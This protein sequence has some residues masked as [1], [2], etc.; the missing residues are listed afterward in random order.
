[1]QT[2]TPAAALASV[3]CVATVAAQSP[4][5]PG[6]EPAIH[7]P[8]ITQQMIT[9]GA[10]SARAIRTH[11]L[12]MF[13]TPFNTLDGYGDGP[14]DP[15]N[16]TSP[17]GRPTLQGNGML[18][19]VNGLD[20][21]T[22]T[23]CHSLLSTAEVPFRFGIGGF[24]GANNNVLFMPRH[25]DVSDSNGNGFAAFDGRFI[26]PPFLLGAG[27]V[28]LVAKEMTLELQAAR[29]AAQANQGVWVP[30]QTKG[31]SFGEILWNGASFD[32]SRIEGIDDDLVVRPFGRKGEFP[33]IRSFDVEALRF[34]LGM[35][36]V[37][38]VGRNIDADGDGV[39]NEVLVG[40]VSALS[41]FAA[42]L[43]RPIEVRGDRD[44]AHGRALFSRLGCAQ[45]HVPEIDTHS[46]LLPH[47][48]PEVPTDPLANIY[49]LTD[50]RQS[51]KFD[52]AGG[53]GI[54]RTAVLGPQAS[55]HGQSPGRV[56]RHDPSTG[57]S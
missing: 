22:C 9:S 18:L 23:E 34:H 11:G 26:N 1:M 43:E 2:L 57:C 49:Y 12:R 55:R 24:G 39:V 36:P 17:G 6:E 19:R 29:A 28:E 8:R 3:L 53:G 30:L 54:A 21:Q 46:R 37:E 48:Y 5:M 50:L 32:T 16:T 7:P 25:I 27:G 44:S 20:A 41:I 42:S 14:M 51:A 13:A 45:C 47:A 31:V 38:A 52:H 10:L 56:V 33:T 4:F 35:Q 15:T 40:E